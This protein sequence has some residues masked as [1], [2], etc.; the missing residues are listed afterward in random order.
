MACG[1]GRWT[2]SHRAWLAAAAG[3]S[4]KRSGAV[5][6]SFGL[7]TLEKVDNFEC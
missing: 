4:P 5:G 2:G 6:K 1:A 7:T 3:Y